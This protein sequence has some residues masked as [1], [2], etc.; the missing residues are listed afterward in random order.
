MNLLTLRT[1]KYLHALASVLIF[2][3]VHFL[4]HNAQLAAGVAVL[5]HV[6]K[7]GWDVGHGL[8][9]M[10]DILGD[11]AAGVVGALLAWGCAL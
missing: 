7:K 6:A 3:V 4:T 8:R 10:D 1:D 2:A 5:A 11:I 9:D